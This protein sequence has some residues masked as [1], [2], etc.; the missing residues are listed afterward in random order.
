MEQNEKTREI[1]KRRRHMIDFIE[2]LFA[3]AGGMFFAAAL[4]VSLPLA[5]CVGGVELLTAGGVLL[6][7]LFRPPRRK[8]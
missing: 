6:A 1:E 5:L 3:I 4:M 8:E 7:I 2:L